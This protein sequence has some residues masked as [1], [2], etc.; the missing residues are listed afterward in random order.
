MGIFN[1]RIGDTGSSL[2][3]RSRSN[4]SLPSQEAA[5]LRGQLAA[6]WHTQAVIEFKTD[7]II[8]NAN[9]KFLNTVGYSLDE[10]RGRH[11]HLFV[12][13]K[14]RHSAEYQN[15]WQE[16]RNGKAQQG[17]FRRVGKQGKAVWINASYTPIRNELGV[18]FKIVKYASDI[19]DQKLQNMDYKG[20]LG[21]INNSQAV[22]E[23]TPEGNVLH[24]NKLFLQTLGY[25]LA[26]IT[27][28]HHSQ[29]VD[30]NE[31]QSEA[32]KKFWTDLG[33]G[34]ANTGTFRR[35]DKAGRD[36]WIN[37]T[38]TPIK[39][40]DGKVLKVVK[41]ARNITEEIVQSHDNQG[42]IKAIR[43]S[44]AVIQFAVDGT[45]LD[46]NELFLL[47]TG[48]SLD[49]IK[50]KHHQL[51][52]DPE[53]RNSAEYRHFWL[54]LAAGNVK[55]G[56][57]RRITKAGREIWM[58][59]NYTPIYDI[60]GKVCKVVKYATD[61]TEQKRTVQELTRII[62]AVNQG[63]LSQRAVCDCVNA[64]NQ[65]MRK[66]INLMLDTITEP[67]DEVSNVM[68]AVAQKNLTL[69]VTGNYQGSLRVMKDNVNLALQQ[70]RDSLL[71]VR[72]SASS[73][74]SSSALIAGN[75]Q[76]LS[77]RAEEDSANLEETAAAMEQMTATVEQNTNNSKQAE[78]LAR[79][80][81]TRAEAGGAVVK[82]AIAAMEA[83]NDSSKK[84]SEIISV[85]DAIA[86]QTNLLALNAAVEAA[87]A[88]EQGRGFAVVADE[89][90]SLA[91][92]S[93][94]SAKEIKG[95]I[96]DSTAKVN[97]GSTLVNKSGQ[98]L[99]E[100]LTAVHKVSDVVE[101]I[102]SATLEQNSGID[103]INK[104]IQ[105][106]DQSTQRNSAVAEEASSNSTHMGQLADQLNDLVASFRI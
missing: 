36:V 62:D 8:L 85:I 14:Y 2:F 76:E 29:F 78:V 92:R 83:I 75:N 81:R 73:V 61:I 39:D 63:D 106:L 79:E 86:F 21:A 3:A 71:Q 33:N 25:E 60:N 9:T 51:F 80:A 65:S 41:Y 67:L 19:S 52:V 57:F 56:D 101:E 13:D 42:Q 64:D 53:Y 38:Y 104:A 44:Q 50:G 31:R 22:I 40:T 70:L 96:A 10:V 26:E 72:A 95:L 6:I 88:G 97:H 20:Q 32:Y 66:N 43:S 74:K 100:I 94:T 91:G 55:S 12:D 59:A 48:Y 47:G 49:E 5:D 54:D 28:K 105:E 99:G 15:F 45:I 77:Q 58:H 27:G 69:E 93:A 11:H 90:R 87:R 103:S 30:G 4:V 18:V 46:A 24:A 16:L 34:N 84:I 17:E 23:F 7:G 102:M 37:A 68:N 89:V 98:T 1:P 35:V 82:D